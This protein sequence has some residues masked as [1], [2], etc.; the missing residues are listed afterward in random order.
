MKKLNF[1]LD[2]NTRR[3]FYIS[4]GSPI[5]KQKSSALQGIISTLDLYSFKINNW[6]VQIIY[7]KTTTLL[8]G[9]PFLRNKQIIYNKTY[10]PF[11]GR[12][13]LKKQT[14]NFIYLNKV[15]IFWQKRKHHN[16]F[17]SSAAGAWINETKKKLKRSSEKMCQHKAKILKQSTNIKKGIPVFTT[18]FLHYTEH[19]VLCYSVRCNYNS[20]C[21]C[22]L[23][24]NQINTLRAFVSFFSL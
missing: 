22:I 2:N 4:S 14:Q 23:I 1:K 16:P 20:I 12:N 3:L 19:S 11:R 6:K 8:E 7:N 13:I 21:N 18:G 15:H 5:N 17:N 24:N 9:E 10:H